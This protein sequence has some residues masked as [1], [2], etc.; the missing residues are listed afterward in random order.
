VRNN[1][2]YFGILDGIFRTHCAFLFVRCVHTTCA[3]EG[4]APF[5][6]PLLIST[7]QV[8]IHGEILHPHR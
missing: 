3:L 6:P 1:R 5:F 7:H 4:V 8:T 2:W